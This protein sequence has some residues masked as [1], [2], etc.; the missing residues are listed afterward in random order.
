M[1]DGDSNAHTPPD[2]SANEGPHKPQYSIVALHGILA[3]RILSVLVIF[4]GGYYS[5]SLLLSSEYTAITFLSIPKVCIS[6]AHRLN[7]LNLDGS[8]QQKL[9]KARLALIELLLR[10]A[11]GLCIAKC[12]VK[13]YAK[14]FAGSTLSEQP[15]MGM[16]IGL[17]ILLL[18]GRVHDKLNP[19][20]PTDTPVTLARLRNILCALVGLPFLPG[21]PSAA[22]DAFVA[23]GRIMVGLIRDVTMLFATF[24]LL[25]SGNMPTSFVMFLKIGMVVTPAALAPLIMDGIIQQFGESYLMYAFAIIFGV[26][27]FGTLLFRFVASPM[28]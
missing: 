19:C 3:V 18:L 23:M 13:R 10:V 28:R 2:G 8:A 24:H 12:V 6:L 20:N 11:Y 9:V 7:L 22:M 21:N 15:N 1:L 17:L 25:F 4:T 5:H 26:S 14:I 16:P 27:F